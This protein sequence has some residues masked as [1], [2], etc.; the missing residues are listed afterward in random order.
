MA[1]DVWSD[2]N[3]L[4]ALMQRRPGDPLRQTA[5]K[6]WE[7][8]NQR[9]S[10]A[11]SLGATQANLAETIRS[12]EA[13]Q[14]EAEA[15]RTERAKETAGYREDILSQRAEAQKNAEAA[16]IL[17]ALQYETDPKVT[18]QILSQFYASHGVA[19]PT[20][21]PDPAVEAA[22]RARAASG[23]PVANQPV[24]GQPPVEG[25][26]ERPLTPGQKRQEEVAGGRFSP[27][28]TVAPSGTAPA[29]SEPIR[30]PEGLTL[31]E[32]LKSAPSGTQLVQAG[33]GG[34]IYAPKTPLPGRFA[35]PGGE[36]RPPGT[37]GY[38]NGQP[39]G[40]VIAAGA[41]RTGVTPQSES[42]RTALASQLSKEG[43][44]FFSKTTEPTVAPVVAATPPAPGLNAR[45]GTA[46]GTI[47]PLGAAGGRAISAISAGIGNLFG[48]PEPTKP[49]FGGKGTGAGSEWSP[50]QLASGPTPEP[51]PSGPTP[52]GP[53]SGSIGNITQ[54]PEATPAGTPPAVPV[55]GGTPDIPA[56]MQQADRGLEE[57]RRRMAQQQPQQ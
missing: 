7:L 54:G 43:L 49:T 45:L 26:S 13:G 8:L 16:R 17:T 34:Y 42:G 40:D 36:V 23:Q 18:K 24:T 19:P 48:G 5:E 46:G 52:T 37:V 32:M 25:V 51:T 11:A 10:Q 28:G 14:K 38:I 22:R 20:A 29:T 47:D 56:A 12:R 33:G 15:A 2:R 3:Y 27:S 31:S 57:L 53:F 21:A 35:T 39:A 41:L 50:N 1:T 44:P 6:Q 55:P 4:M 30:P 9:E